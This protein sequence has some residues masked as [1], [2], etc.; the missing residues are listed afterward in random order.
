[1]NC[2]FTLCDRSGKV[3]GNGSSFQQVSIGFTDHDMNVDLFLCGECVKEMY[4]VK[5][6]FTKSKKAIKSMNDR[7]KLEYILNH[8]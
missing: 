6:D 2:S 8:R 3:I 1:M 5:D 7:E 4:K